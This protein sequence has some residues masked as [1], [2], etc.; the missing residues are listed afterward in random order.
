[1]IVDLSKSVEGVFANQDD[2]EKDEDVHKRFLSRQES[3]SYMYVQARQISTNKPIICKVINPQLLYDEQMCTT[4]DENHKTT[5]QQLRLMR[6]VVNLKQLNHPTIVSFLGFNMYN[7]KITFF[8]GSSNAALNTNPTIYLEYLENGPLEDWI[9]NDP[10]TVGNCPF[11]STK[12]QICMIG[13]SSALRLLHKK[14]IIHRGLNPKA[15]WLDSNFYPKV[16][17]FSSSR[18]YDPNVDIS[19]T[20]TDEA[21]EIYQ[22]PEFRAETGESKYNNLIDIFSLGRIF[23][24]MAT[25]GEP[26]KL[27]GFKVQAQRMFNATLRFPNTVSPQLRELIECCCDPNPNERPSAQEVYSLLASNIYEYRV[28][29]NVNSDEIENYVNSIEK[30]ESEHIDTEFKLRHTFSFEIPEVNQEASEEI[31]EKLVLLSNL[32]ST[33]FEGYPSDSS[34]NLIMELTQNGEILKGN[35]L[36]NISHFLNTASKNGQTVADDI[37]KL[38]YGDYVVENGKT[39]IL[40]KTIEDKAIKTANIPPSVTKIGKN[41][42]KNFVFLEKVNIPESVEII[43]ESAFS[44]CKK[45]NTVNIPY[46]IV[47]DKLGKTVFQGCTSL[48]CIIIPPTITIINDKTFK[49]NS[50]LT[51]VVLSEGLEKIGKNSFEDCSSLKSIEVPESVKLIDKSAFKGCPSLGLVMLKG[52]SPKIR[53]SA[54][55]WNL[56]TLL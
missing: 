19:M 24:I 15:I 18:T 5:Y 9:R 17:D 47:G 7:E 2:F 40:Q 37:L 29:D 34:L 35:Y 33:N 21:K 46:S 41:A 49:K 52:K 1:M 30:F 56:K 25:G 23:Y 45:L 48:K 22:A 36:N 16:F 10:A 3:G 39:E 4:L 50:S 11:N 32:I 8:K 6:E 28:D 38:I 42:F 13:L 12:R 53:V 14:K 31:Q 51:S 55:A 20:M 26:F 44:G 27:K 43:E 54:I